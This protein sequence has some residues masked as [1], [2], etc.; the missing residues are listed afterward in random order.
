VAR[1]KRGIVAMQNCLL[2]ALNRRS[3]TGPPRVVNNGAPE[4]ETAQAM[5]RTKHLMKAET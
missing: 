2:P 3:T 1:S 4:Y 5:L